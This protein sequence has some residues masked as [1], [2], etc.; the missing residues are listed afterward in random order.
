VDKIR[1]KLFSQLIRQDI[2][3][4][5]RKENRIGAL[6][7]RLTEDVNLMRNLA[8]ESVG[9]IL[10]SVSSFVCA[11]CMSLFFCWEMGLCVLAVS[12]FMIA[13][14]IFSGRMKT[15]FQGPGKAAV[16]DAS[17]VLVEAIESIKT[18]HGLVRER[19]FF[20][21][22]FDALAGKVKGIPIWSTIFAFS[23]AL[24]SCTG[25]LV[26]AFGFYV[27]KEFVKAG[28]TDF[29]GM[30]K[31]MGTIMFGAMAISQLGNILPEIIAAFKPTQLIYNVIDRVPQIDSFSPEGQELVDTLGVVEFK[32]VCF[33]TQLDRIFWF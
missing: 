5:D 6:V 24:G 17:V 16:E 19:Y 29:E 23:Q 3:F 2:S 10:N 33:Y 13:V 20:E 7:N 9:F 31:G 21:K 4:F 28:I 26:S 27:G 18:V 32:N 14:I 15:K 1:K 12:P 22:Y 8:G 25:Y 30:F 11:V